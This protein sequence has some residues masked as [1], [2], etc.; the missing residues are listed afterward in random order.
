MLVDELS[1]YKDFIA[2]TLQQQYLT[3]HQR[4]V[5]SGTSPARF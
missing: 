4:V 5:T 2:L 1:Y 3:G